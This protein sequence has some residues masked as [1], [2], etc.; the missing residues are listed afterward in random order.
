MFLHLAGWTTPTDWTLQWAA[1]N[2][3][4]ALCKYLIEA[5]ADVNAVGGES[6]ATPA[7]WAAQRCHPYTVHL[8]LQHG[9]DP[10]LRD[11]QGYNVLHMATTDG[12]VFQLL[13]ILHQNIPVDTTDPQGHTSLMWA[14]YRGY[15]A[16]ADILLKWGASISARDQDGFTPLHWA[17]VKG[18]QTCIQKLIEFGAD[19]F[20]ETND[21]K[22]PAIVAQEMMSQSQWHRA[23]RELGFNTDGTVKQLPS[24]YLSFVKT[25]TFLDRFFFLIPF[26]LLYVVFYILA[27]MPIY[28]A[29]PISMFLAYSL[30]W[31]AQ[32]VLQ[33]AP[34]SMKHLHRTVRLVPIC[35]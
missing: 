24:P 17:L 12:N 13:I 29:V 34:R 4:Y 25:R 6:H 3:Q 32:Q 26:A 15:P 28:A 11:D 30:Q 8:L 14:V 23:L 20:A 21:G 35:A 9:A 31:V 22:S 19:R 2:N 1:I 10:L 5:G 33:W 7:A 27:K 16:I 18:N